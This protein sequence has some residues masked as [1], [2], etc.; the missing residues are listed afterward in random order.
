MADEEKKESKDKKQESITELAEDLAALQEET[1]KSGDE[2]KS[3]GLFANKM[4]LLIVG[5][6]SLVVVLVLTL[7]VVLFVMDGDNSAEEPPGDPTEQAAEQAEQPDAEAHAETAPVDAAAMDAA[8]YG[9]A[10][11]IPELTEE[12]L[13]A[14]E[15]EFTGGDG[16]NDRGAQMNKI[17]EELAEIE[18]DSADLAALA[19]DKEVYD[20]AAKARRDS[21]RIVSWIDEQKALIEKR[22]A[23]LDARELDLKSIE[24]SVD[25]KITRLEQVESSRTGNLA[26]LYDGMDARAVANLMANL[27]DETVLSILPRM[28]TKNASAVLSLL[29]PR[30][31]A[32]LSKELITITED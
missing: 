22:E 23:D 16:G 10:A 28:N 15:A 17:M 19:E 13:A 4:M 21:A 27:D 8:D 9:D 2:K 31:A 1:G 26:R 12:E 14:L 20:P 3:G 25:K 7:V 29:P 32:K 18:L 5:L 24:R 30:R 6:G 11:L